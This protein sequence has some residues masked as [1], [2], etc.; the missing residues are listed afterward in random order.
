M[1]GSFLLKVINRPLS[2][3]PSLKGVRVWIVCQLTSP[4]PCSERDIGYDDDDD[5]D[6][7]GERLIVAKC[8]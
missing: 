7:G 4:R 1:Q 2:S 6:E 3:R 5:D 8:G